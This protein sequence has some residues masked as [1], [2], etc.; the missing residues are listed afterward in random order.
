MASGYYFKPDANLPPNERSERR[1]YR[2]YHDLPGVPQCVFSHAG[3]LIKP[4]GKDL[5]QC[6][7]EQ[8]ILWTRRDLLCILLDVAV[9]LHAMH[10]RR[11]IHGDVK[12]ENVVA[13]PGN[14]IS[15]SRDGCSKPVTRVID[16]G[17]C[18]FDHPM[19]GAVPLARASSP[20][21]FKPRRF[22]TLACSGPDQWR[23]AV[24]GAFRITD[25]V[26][27]WCFGLMMHHCLFGNLT[28]NIIWPD[29]TCYRGPLYRASECV[30]E[31]IKAIQLSDAPAT[32]KV[33]RTTDLIRCI[34]TALRHANLRMITRARNMGQ[35]DRHV[36]TIIR[37]L[38]RYDPERRWTMDRTVRELRRLLDDHPNLSQTDSVTS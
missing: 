18:M 26:D 33:S 15:M 17:E 21:R 27:R 3:L 12:M 7:V 30:V 11:L 31:R 25:A 6:V 4:C 2:E 16:F 1:F 9:T 32:H 24:D 13:K 38:T 36:L 19:H 20:E 28:V 34:V 37:G 14:A 10:E 8:Q 35:I 22:G 5:F 23:Q 29:G